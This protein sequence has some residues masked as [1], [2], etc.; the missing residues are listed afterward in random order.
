MVSLQDW[1]EFYSTLLTENKTEFIE[2]EW[3]MGSMSL[4]VSDLEVDE[5]LYRIFMTGKS[6]GLG[7]VFFDSMK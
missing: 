6:P 3:K 2:E 1:Y 5:A 4:T 7:N